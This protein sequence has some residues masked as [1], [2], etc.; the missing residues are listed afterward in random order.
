VLNIPDEFEVM[1]P[2]LQQILRLT[3]DPEFKHLTQNQA[4]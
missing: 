2:E 4:D 1:D 3:L